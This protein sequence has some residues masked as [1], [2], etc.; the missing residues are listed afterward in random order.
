MGT[1]KKMTYVEIIDEIRDEMEMFVDT[2]E[3]SCQY[4]SSSDRYCR[5][6]SQQSCMG[7]N[8]FMPTMHS[9][10]TFLYDKYKEADYKSKAKE[11]EVARLEETIEQ[12][13]EFIDELKEENCAL[14]GVED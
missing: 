13:D 4:K 11:R 14:I 12:L 8:F 7:C 5:A 1:D 6:T 10:I 3:K 9:L 2:M